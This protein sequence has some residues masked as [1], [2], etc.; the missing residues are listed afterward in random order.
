M[1]LREPSNRASTAGASD[2]ARILDNKL[3][4]E[5]TSAI[6]RPTMASYVDVPISVSSNCS[7]RLNRRWRSSSKSCAYLLLIYFTFPPVGLGVL[8]VGAAVRHTPHVP[9]RI[10]RSRLFGETIGV[11]AVAPASICPRLLVRPLAC[12][13]CIRRIRN[14]PF[15]LS[16]GLLLGITSTCGVGG[17]ATPTRGPAAL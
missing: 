2:P 16:C 11:G 10:D 1:M 12:K 14:S 6:Q 17:H 8:G 4:I 5:K 7:T 3:I 15:L 13:Y 9:P